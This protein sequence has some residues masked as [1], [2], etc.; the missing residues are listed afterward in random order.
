MQRYIIETRPRVTRSSCQYIFPPNAEL[1]GRTTLGYLLTV[2]I[3]I[4]GWQQFFR[5]DSRQ[6]VMLQEW[7]GHRHLQCLCLT[8]IDSLSGP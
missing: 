5:T 1:R 8:G 4:A 2:Q 3:Q 7:P 6:K